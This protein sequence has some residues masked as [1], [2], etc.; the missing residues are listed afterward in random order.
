MFPRV[1][2]HYDVDAASLEAGLECKDESLTLQ[3]QAQDAD[4]NVIL[5]RF[6]VTGELPNGLRVPVY[7]NFEGVSDYR[8]ALD[9]IR[10]ADRAFMSLPAEVRNRF[11]NDA[12]AFVDFASNPANLE[13]LRKMGLAPKQEVSNVQGTGEVVE[14]KQPDAA[15]G[16]AAVA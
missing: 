11:A 4:I 9:L 3:S 2:G 13:E 12:G 6:G 15:S 8:E 7:G 16:K 10:E 1:A 14:G 5:K